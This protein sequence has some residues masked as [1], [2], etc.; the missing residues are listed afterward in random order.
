MHP[1]QSIQEAVDRAASGD[2]ITIAP[3]EYEE[4]VCIEGKG[5]TIRG[6]GADR[7]VISWPE[8]ATVGDLPDVEATA[9]WTAQQEVDGEDVEP[10]LA[11]N[12]SGLFFLRPD[13]P[14]KVTGLTTRNHPA[15]GIL[16]WG[17]DGFTVH[18]HEGHAHDR[19]GI[20]ALDS[21]DIELGGNVE[22]GLDRSSDPLVPDS[23][24]A[25]IGVGDSP[26][27]RA[28]ISGNHL[29][30]YN[31]GLFL[32]EARGGRVAGNSFTGN[33]IG[34]L[35][36]DDVGTEVADTSGDVQTGDFRVT[37]NSSTA[38]NRYCLQGREGDQHVSGVGMQVVN[39]D[40][41]SFHGNRIEDNRPVLPA[42]V[43]RLTNPAGGLTLFTLPPF[44]IQPGQ[45]PAGPVEDVRASG[46]RF[47]DN[48]GILGPGGP[49]QMDIFVGAPG[50][51]V[52]FLPAGDGLEFR[53]NR[54]DASIPPTIC[55]E[56]YP[57]TP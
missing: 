55:G 33:C 5:L 8:W 53:G 12:V 20:L 6:A 54:C 35:V 28:R 44:G 29:E 2:T 10:T 3:G 36:F 41:L 22:I 27:A 19:Y 57:V 26:D 24:T 50:E 17:A 40:G 11:D 39:A 37:G 43:Q 13:Q 46:N 38:N 48:W 18:G 47:G 34:L 30:G 31:L 14:V 45:V 49:V 25:G 51:N 23:G 9:C 15:S 7:T 16:A 56:P 4:A 32:R 52:P 1:G 21:T 42:G